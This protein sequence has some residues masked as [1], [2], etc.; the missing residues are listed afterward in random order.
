[1][2]IS[3]GIVDAHVHYWNPGLLTYSWL[4]ELPSL[5]RPFLPQDYSEVSKL[6]DVRKMIFVE[7]GCDPSQS[8][9]EVEWASSL[10]LEDSRISGIV[11]HAPLEQGEAVR[12][13]LSQ[14]S[15]RPLVKGVRRLLQGESEVDFCLN[16]DFITGVRLLKE[17]NFSM[18]LCIR[19]EQLASVTGLVRK[20][21]GVDFVLDH[22]GKPPVKAGALEPW[23]SQLRMLAGLPNVSCKVSGLAT[24]AEWQTWRPSDLKPYFET[25]LEFFGTDRVIFGGDWPVC[26]LASEYRRWLDTVLELTDSLSATACR[27]L[28]HSNAART[29][30]L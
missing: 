19:H 4:K 23:R 14:L 9:A 20:V 22:F 15:A 28:F 17:F 5:D 26:T 2:K 25:V 1:M 12:Q 10:S 16:P 21:P 27:K 7:S 6:A 24:E 29:Y 30:H 18:D 3:G 11:A 8:L 13:H